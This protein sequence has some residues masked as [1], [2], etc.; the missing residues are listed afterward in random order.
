MAVNQD[1]G[2]VY[3]VHALV[4]GRHGLTVMDD[5]RG[6]VVATMA[7]DYSHPL[8]AAYAVAVDEKA[9]RLY[10]AAEGELLVINGESHDLVA[11]V[12]T[13]AIAYNFG[14]AVDQ[15]TGRVCVADVQEAKVL[16]FEGVR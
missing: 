9:N 8:G 2:R 12:P 5:Q 14:L 1:T 4:P 11:V 15:A 7:G 16:I 13:E 3:I 10:L 6:E